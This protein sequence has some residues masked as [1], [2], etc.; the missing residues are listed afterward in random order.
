MPRI[1]LLRRVAEEAAPGQHFDVLRPIRVRRQRFVKEGEL[2]RAVELAARQTA[3][4]DGILILLD[5]TFGP[6]APHRR[7]ANSAAICGR[8]CERQPA[9]YAIDRWGRLGS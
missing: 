3:A 5:A 9:G 2:E 4:T 7:S 8:F 6:L 1:V